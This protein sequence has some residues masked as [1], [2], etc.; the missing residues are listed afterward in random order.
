M[1]KYELNKELKILE[2][3]YI[4]DIDL[5]ELIE[6]GEMIRSDNSLPRDLRILTN[7][8]A[9]IYHL[10]RTDITEMMTVLKDQIK[11]YQTIKTAVIQEKPV[12]TAISMLV[13]TGAPIPNYEHKV[14]STREA[15]LMWLNR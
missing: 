12:E 7:A 5:K 1:I 10:S 9:A 2:V 11:P 8:S 6:Y 3:H 4:G 15:A 14:F 13:D